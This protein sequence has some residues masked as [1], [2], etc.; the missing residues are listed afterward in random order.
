MPRLIRL[1]LLLALM[2]SACA[3]Q[4]AAPA[5][6]PTAQ[7]QSGETASAAPPASA[8]PAAQP[9]ETALPTPSPTPTVLP[10][11]AYRFTVALDYDRHTAAVT[12]EIQYANRSGEAL[13]D[14]RLVV[15]PE[16]YKGAFTLESIAWADGQ[17]IPNAN[18]QENQALVIPLAQPLAPGG[19]LALKLTYALALP[20][21]EAVAGERPVPFGYK[22][23]QTNLV[24]WYP[25]IPPYRPGQGWLVN[26]PGYYGEH[27]VAESAD[28]AVELRL[29]SQRALIVAASS[30]EEPGSDGALK[31]YRLEQGRSF[32]ISA[33]PD[34]VV[35][36]QELGG[37][38]VESYAFPI[39]AAAGE[40]AG[41]VTGEALGVFS[42]RFG[43]LPLPRNH[44]SVVEADFL[45]GMEYDGLYFL[46]DG[47]YNLYAGQPGEYLTAIAAH[48]TAHQ[49][50]FA[51]TGS[52]QANEPWLDEALCTYSERLYYEL[53]HP[54]ALD[55]W[56]G[57]RVN[58]FGPQ[59][60]VDSSV[61]EHIGQANSYIQYRNAVYLNGAVFLEALRKAVGDEA[62]FA[63]LQ[64]YA[65]TTAGKL[66][67]RAD[68]FAAV[69]KFTAV[70]LTPLVKQYF[71]NP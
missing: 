26:K 17:A 69:A 37:W 60:W 55:W 41:R 6:T 57:A 50:W 25:F 34:Y 66:A 3:P 33:S 28:F 48:E 14:L 11:P 24:D 7:P 40:A 58:F 54:E 64:D 39:H 16:Q 53:V 13:A 22:E 68:F 9:S 51:S 36:R 43:P 18:W 67:T 46:S 63:A 70:D 38:T 30:A 10:D 52:D 62:F 21:P 8:T 2:L 59:G 23:R 19:S 35:T 5:A 4:T 1:F 15:P 29:T 47:F 56:W 65:Q 49:W 42:Q 45:D 20:A 27:L 44:L 31:R 12:Q 71:K 32:A 61:Y